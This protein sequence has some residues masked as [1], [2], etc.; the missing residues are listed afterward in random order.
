MSLFGIII[1]TKISFFISEL[2]NSSILITPLSYNFTLTSNNNNTGRKSEK[3][4]LENTLAPTCAVFLSWVD[5]ILFKA[6]G[7]I[8]SQKLCKKSLYS[9]SLYVVVAPIFIS[10]SSTF[11]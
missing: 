9:K 11:M 3:A 10:S 7:I 1:S 8:P 2:I 5:T 6:F 4:Y